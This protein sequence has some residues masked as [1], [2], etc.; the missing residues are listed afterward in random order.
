MATQ[1]L[2][3]CPTL[4]IG[5]RCGART[6][7]DA[8]HQVK[9]LVR[10]YGEGHNTKLEWLGFDAHHRLW[11][12]KSEPLIPVRRRIISVYQRQLDAC[13]K[14]LKDCVN[15]RKKQCLEQKKEYVDIMRGFE[16]V[17]RPDGKSFGEDWTYIE[18]ELIGDA[19]FIL[20]SDADFLHAIPADRVNGV[21]LSTPQNFCAEV[22]YQLQGMKLF[23]ITLSSPYLQNNV[24]A[25]F[26]GMGMPRENKDKMFHKI[27][28][29]GYIRNLFIISKDAKG[30][31]RPVNQ[32]EDRGRS[33][34][35]TA[36]GGIVS[37]Y[38]G[39][40]IR[41]PPT[42][43]MEDR[44][45]RDPAWWKEFHY[46]KKAFPGC[47]LPNVKMKDGILKAFSPT[48]HG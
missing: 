25:R 27:G 48:C 8:A 42:E 5:I 23:G 35:E 15:K 33:L 2:P 36:N 29:D 32:L 24:G 44:H 28:Y 22:A 43:K 46:L 30:I 45:Y 47:K 3:E 34:S 7:E 41:Y 6:E 37:L 19:E 14:A 13:T 31:W 1:N 17:G 18:K 38:T 21:S 16:V 12:R 39:A 40:V 10:P 26:E 9:S 20:I 4:T 11:N